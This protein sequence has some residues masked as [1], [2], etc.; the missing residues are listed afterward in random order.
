M[1]LWLKINRLNS[2]MEKVK[3]EN[4]DE[5]DII[6][7]IKNGDG[8]AFTWLVKNYQNR[9]ANLIY[10]V[11]GDSSIVEDIT[12][13]VFIKI[14]ESIK[15]YKFESALYTWIYRITVNICIDEIRRRKRSRTSGFDIIK[16]NP[17]LEP[18][19][20]PIERIVENRELRE[21]LKEAMMKLPADFRVIIALREFEDLSYEE[22]SNILGI[23]IGTVKSRIFRARQLLAEYLKDYMEELK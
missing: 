18:A 11:I 13:E 5:K 17:G 1:E 2:R 8:D 12:Q 3:E 15:N 16:K 14:F 4:V 22:I 7:R 10:K 9:V 6:E 20:S 21:I 19:D 23:R